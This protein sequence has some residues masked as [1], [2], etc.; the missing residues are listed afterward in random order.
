MDAR[1]LERQVAYDLLLDRLYLVDDG[2][3]VKG[4]TAPAMPTS[5]L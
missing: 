4:A 5:A 3:I 1:K 2:W